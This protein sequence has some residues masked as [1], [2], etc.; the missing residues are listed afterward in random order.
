M[1]NGDAGTTA[2][3]TWKLL[4]KYQP[5]GGDALYGRYSGS[6][7]FSPGLEP[8]PYNVYMWWTSSDYRSQRVPVIVR[9]A[10]GDQ[11]LK[12][13][14]R[15]GGGQWNLLGTF[16][17]DASSFV[18]IL[19]ATKLYNV[20][21][22]AVQFVPVLTVAEP[23]PDPTPP[24]QTGD[25]PPDLPPEPP[26][27]LV[28]SA[29]AD[30]VDLDW[31]DNSEADLSAYFVYRSLS[32]G[33]S[34]QLVASRL[35]TSSYQDTSVTN[36]VTYYYVV[37]ATD[38]GGNE[39]DDSPEVSATPVAPVV[40][41]TA[42]TLAWAPPTVN[43]DGT[44]LTDLAGFKLYMGTASRNY[45]AVTDIGASTTY[46]FSSLLPGTYYFCVTAYDTTGN[47]SGPSAEVTKTVLTPPGQIGD[48]PPAPAPTP[49]PVPAP[50]PAP[51]PVDLPP[52]PPAGLVASAQ[53]GAVDLDWSDNS[54]ADLSAYFVYRSLS[55][56]GSYQLVAG[57]LTTSSY[58]DTSVTNGV[59]YYYVVTAMD[60]GGNES[61]QSLEVS[62][63]PVAP[64][65]HET[66]AA[67]AWNPPSKNSD[68]TPLTDLAGFKVYMGTASRNYST[69]MDVGTSTTYT[70]NSLLPG[71]YYFCVTAYDT[72]GNQSS[73][74]AEVTKT[75]Q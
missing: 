13:N 9:T 75:L 22:D 48:P 37:T 54:E 29:K 70:F 23:P 16:D 17:L 51:P 65:V 14:Q 12:V 43:T 74:S 3:G 62:A 21:A 67:L 26:A 45:S 47:Q 8:G 55:S 24:A 34:Y 25:P 5:Y 41:D 28:S 61:G 30:A 64:V 71:T 15:V 40:G 73:P 60:S 68:G 2:V 32:S 19:V 18:Q 4:T 35:T 1:D 20:C 66:T 39:S 36:G 52:A 46:T 53:T 27:G 57:S 69:V 58:Q 44:P 56:G 11:A 72:T 42:T 63:T 7:T 10:N 49:T 31:S 50:T 38:S 6:Y 59:T 33:G